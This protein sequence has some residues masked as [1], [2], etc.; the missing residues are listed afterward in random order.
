LY[1]IIL[2]AEELYINPPEEKKDRL[3][4]LY[5]HFTKNLVLSFYFNEGM[6]FIHHIG[7]QS[8]YEKKRFKEERNKIKRSKGFFLY[9]YLFLHLII[10]WKMMFLAY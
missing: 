5:G 1:G 10:D 3:F 6:I 2:T 9:K 4:A 8:D 7:P